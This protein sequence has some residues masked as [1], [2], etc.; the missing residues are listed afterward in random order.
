VYKSSCFL[1]VLV[2]TAGKLRVAHPSDPGLEFIMQLLPYAEFY[3]ELS[4]H[5]SHQSHALTPEHYVIY[6][7]KLTYVVDY[8]ML[9]IYYSTDSKFQLFRY[10]VLQEH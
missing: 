10:Y 3:L 1:E 5:H 8:Y 6:D 7:S 9:P 4:Y 2:G